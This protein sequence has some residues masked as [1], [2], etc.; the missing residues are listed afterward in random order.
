MVEFEVGLGR[1]HQ[2]CDRYRLLTMQ[3][4]PSTVHYSVQ[5]VQL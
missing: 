4:L 2:E 3:C 1:N 5:Q